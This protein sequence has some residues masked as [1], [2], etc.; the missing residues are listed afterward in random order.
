[1]HG[2][3][4]QA[5]RTAQQHELLTAD[6]RASGI[7]PT[8][9]GFFDQ[10]AFLAR[11]HSHVDYLTNYAEWVVT[12]PI[13]ADYAAHVTTTVPT[14]ALLLASAFADCGARGCCV[15]ASNMMIRMLD[16]LHVWSFCIFGSV[17]IEAPAL[18]MQLAIQTVGFKS[19]PQNIVGHTW[20]CAPPYLIVGTTLALQNWDAVIAPLIPMV[21]L[22]DA[23]APRVYAQVSDC[24]NEDIRAF[25]AHREGWRDPNL[26]F[27]R[28]PKLPGMLTWF[29]ARD[30]TAR[31]IRVRFVP[32]MI[33][34]PAET[35]AQMEVD[36]HRLSGRAMWN[37]VVGPAFG[38]PPLPR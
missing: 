21:V 33:R 29:P 16:L 6:F 8:Q 22:A 2:I 32:V 7:D 1:M 5:L 38:M 11:E 30:V 35:L 15:A 24:V 26:H 3:S 20:V 31:D 12:R 14:L 36:D 23:Q 10:P 4:K 34:Q 9:F 13:S 25:F 28:N 18:G 19:N 17:V 27:R 37:D